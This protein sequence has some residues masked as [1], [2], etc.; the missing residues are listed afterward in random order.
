MKLR[1]NWRILDKQLKSLRQS[2]LVR[3]RREGA[4]PCSTMRTAHAKGSGKATIFFNRHPHELIEVDLYLPK[5]LRDR[6]PF[7]MKILCGHASE[8]YSVPSR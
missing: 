7:V 4:H 5:I 3:A 2:I 1:W 8:A 6:L